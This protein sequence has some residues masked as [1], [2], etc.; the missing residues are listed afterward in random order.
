MLMKV[1]H[2]QRNKII[3][4]SKRIS[5]S[6]ISKVKIS[7]NSTHPSITTANILVQIF[8]DFFLSTYIQTQNI[9]QKWNIIHGI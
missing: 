2:A 8:P 5:L 6:E 3:R 9:K 7:H 1:M 4:R